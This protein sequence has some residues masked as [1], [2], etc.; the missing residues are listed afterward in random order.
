M[1]F[2]PNLKQ[3]FRDFV[4]VKTDSHNVDESINHSNVIKDSNVTINVGGRLPAAEK[5][6]VVLSDLRK[7][8]DTTEQLN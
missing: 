8:S 3:L 7:E 1:R 2:F 4:K 5:P 6:N